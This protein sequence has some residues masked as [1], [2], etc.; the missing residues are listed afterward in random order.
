MK[1]GGSVLM[2][3]PIEWLLTV[4]TAMLITVA[5][6]LIYTLLMLRQELIRAAKLLHDLLTGQKQIDQ[7][8]RRA[9]ER[10]DVVEAGQGEVVRRLDRLEER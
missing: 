10:I 5:G 3:Q 7:N 2:A 1:K 9:W 4:Q 6:V 8:L